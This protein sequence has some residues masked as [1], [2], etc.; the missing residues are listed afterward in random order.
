MAQIT[1]EFVL[2]IPCFYFYPV[3]L[4]WYLFHKRILDNK[5][6]IG[7]SN[8]QFYDPGWKYFKS[9]P[10]IF[11]DEISL[12]KLRNSD[13]R[14]FKYFSFYFILYFSFFYFFTFFFIFLF[15]NFFRL[16]ASQPIFK[17][18]ISEEENKNIEKLCSTASSV[19]MGRRNQDMAT[20]FKDSSTISLKVN[21]TFVN[22]KQ[23][24]LSLWY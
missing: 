2:P 11:F 4:C 15:F 22:I 19:P 18:R 5:M 1:I 21:K 17:N 12:L 20:N 23:N 13:L 24:V 16:C 9:D 14:I 3:L 6:S 8:L 10:I 7:W